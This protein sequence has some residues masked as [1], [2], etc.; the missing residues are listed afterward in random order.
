MIRTLIAISIICLFLAGC[1][2]APSVNMELV[3]SQKNADKSKADI[4]VRTVTGEGPDL[5]PTCPP[6]EY[7][8]TWKENTTPNPYL[9]GE[10]YEAIDLKFIPK[11]NNHNTPFV[12]NYTL[13]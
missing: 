6:V 5:T 7:N 3:N 9:K 1:T 8:I 11:P 2:N 12:S 4:V 10:V 13:Y